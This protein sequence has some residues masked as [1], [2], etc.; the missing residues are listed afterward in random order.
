MR[1]YINFKDTITRNNNF[2]Y[3]FQDLF[4]PYMISFTRDIVLLS[5]T[6]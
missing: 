3:D 6:D 1:V 4:E 5:S 2:M